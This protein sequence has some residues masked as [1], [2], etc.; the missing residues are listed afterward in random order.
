MP[1]KKVIIVQLDFAYEKLRL[2]CGF[3]CVRTFRFNKACCCEINAFLHGI[4]IGKL[5]LAVA[6]CA[7]ILLYL[8]GYIH[9]AH[10]IMKIF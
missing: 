7:L 4:N 10:K 6:V 8:T 3:V 9:E 2:R 1:N 5:R